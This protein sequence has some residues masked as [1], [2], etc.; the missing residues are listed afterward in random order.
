[1]SGAVSA[2]LTVSVPVAGRRVLV[3][4][5]GAVAT[6]RVA[7]LVELGAEVV[8]VAPE[9]SAELTERA[10]AGEIVDPADGDFTVLPA[11]RRGDL[12]VAVGTGGRSPALAAHLRRRL[13]DELTGYEAVLDLLAEVRDDTR[14]AGGSS[15]DVDWRRAF[16]EGIVELVQSGRIEAAREVLA[17]C[18]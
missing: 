5:A 7:T 17:R 14:A 4:G 8:V 16:D 18:R 10:A 3:V 11:V 15:E 1:M 6:R 9:V 13:A 12:V 2:G